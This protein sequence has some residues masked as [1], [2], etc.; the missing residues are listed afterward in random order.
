MYYGAFMLLCVCLGLRFRTVCCYRY[1]LSPDDRIRIF[2]RKIF[3]RNQQGKVGRG[4]GKGRKKEKI[5]KKSER[6]SKCFKT[7]LRSMQDQGVPP[8]HP[9]VSSLHSIWGNPESFNSRPGPLRFPLPPWA[10]PTQSPSHR[11]SHP[12]S[13]GQQIPSRTLTK[14]TALSLPQRWGARAWRGGASCPSHPSGRRQG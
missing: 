10:T 12:T 14:A 1:K 3:L 11:V 8:K 5:K 9:L 2:Q 6:D 13:S 7:Q 4:G